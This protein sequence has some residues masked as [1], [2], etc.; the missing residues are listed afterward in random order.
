VEAKQLNV[1]YIL[2]THVHADHL[3][4]GDR[5]RKETSAELCIGSHISVVQ[6]KFKQVFNLPQLSTDGSQWDRLLDADE[7]KEGELTLGA[8]PIQL[9]HTPGHTPV[10]MSFLI[11]DCVFTGD[12]LFMPDLGTARC[13]FPGGS[14]EDMYSSCRRL[15]ALDPSTR[16]FVGHDYPPASREF[17]WE[18]SVAEQNAD[19]VMIADTISQEAFTTKRLARDA[20]LPVPKL[21]LPSLQININ[22]GTMPV[23]EPGS[24]T[25][26]L[27]IPLT[28][29]ETE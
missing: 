19:N 6:E 1:K 14:V 29:T 4:G 5:L 22:A 27:K 10:C 16:V 23:A 17:R 18:T 13:D 2:E 28:E 24:D 11:D 21:L 9:L 20:G 7:R 12:T 26:Y 8:V 3:S 25:A 15:L